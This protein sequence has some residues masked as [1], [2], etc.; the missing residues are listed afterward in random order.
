V[1]GGPACD[2]EFGMAS[3][4]AALDPIAVLEADL[5]V[6]I[7]EDRTEW[8]VAVVEGLACEVHTSAQVGSIVVT[9]G[10]IW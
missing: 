3:G 10:H 1:V 4:I 2:R 9:D 5:A 6:S 7:D 8:L